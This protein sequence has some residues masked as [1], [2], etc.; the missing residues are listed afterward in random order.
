MDSTILIASRDRGSL[1]FALFMR[2][3]PGRQRATVIS[4]PNCSGGRRPALLMTVFV[5]IDTSKPVEDREHIKLFARKQAADVWFAEY[6]P[7]ASRSNIESGIELLS[8]PTAN[9]NEGGGRP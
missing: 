5:Y 9:R 7:K 1:N 6:N 4:L 2:L 8:C 3:S